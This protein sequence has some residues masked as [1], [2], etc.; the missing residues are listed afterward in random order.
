MD[1]AGALFDKPTSTMREMLDLM[2]EA[3][4]LAKD[5]S[6]SIKEW[7]M[8]WRFSEHIKDGFDNQLPESQE[9]AQLRQDRAR[10][11]E[12]FSPEFMTLMERFCQSGSAA[13][14]EKF[15]DFLFPKEHRARL[16]MI[17]DFASSAE[18]ATYA[19]LFADW[20][21]LKGYSQAE[22]TEHVDADVIERL[23]RQ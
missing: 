21:R 2:H 13:D 3:D 11:K 6:I 14:A 8:L 10:H 15:G 19:R 4:D 22:V 17:L 16:S 20:V 1:K 23:A 18:R 9:L 12:A 7:F 5:P